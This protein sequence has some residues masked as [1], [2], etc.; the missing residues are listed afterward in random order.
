MFALKGVIFHLFGW[1]MLL[2]SSGLAA[3]P[4]A[5]YTPIDSVISSDDRDHIPL[6]FDAFADVN[7]SFTYQTPTVKT[8]PQTYV[9]FLT[10]MDSSFYEFSYYTIGQQIV[11]N[12][13]V[14]AIIFPFH[15]FT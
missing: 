2:G 7:Y 11:V 4:A 1:L 13:S 8:L 6:V 10:A 9:V 5:S 12:L 15:C 3:L 14:K